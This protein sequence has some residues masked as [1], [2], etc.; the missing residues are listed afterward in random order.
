MKYNKED[1]GCL[2]L[3][4]FL[5]IAFPFIVIQAFSNRSAFIVVASIIAGW[6]L[7]LNITWRIV[8]RRGESS[9]TIWEVL[10][11]GIPCMVAIACV[12]FLAFGGNKGDPTQPKT[13]YNA[14]QEYEDE[15]WESVL[16]TA[17][18]VAYYQKNYP[19]VWGYIKKNASDPYSYIEFYHQVWGDLQEY[20]GDG[21]NFDTL[22]WYEQ[23]LVN[24]PDIGSFIYFANPDSKEYHSTNKCYTLLKSY[25]TSSK[26]SA[27]AYKYN[28]CSKCVGD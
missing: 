22:T 19:M 4:V 7:G 10:K 3:I 1:Y 14:R 20:T 26:S 21:I 15:S 28:P 2:A 25:P 5:G 11:Y 9:T 13:K 8:K 12:L 6:I 24:Y 23:S 17:E 27:Y 18:I 16:E